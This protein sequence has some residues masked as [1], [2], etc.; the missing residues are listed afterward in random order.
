MPKQL[1]RIACHWVDEI[2]MGDK[3]YVIPLKFAKRRLHS[4]PTLSSVTRLLSHVT[5]SKQPWGA[6]S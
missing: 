5:V 2:S 4:E 1:P 3:T 6:S